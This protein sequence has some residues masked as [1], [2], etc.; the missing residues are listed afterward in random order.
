[1]RSSATQTDHKTLKGYKLVAKLD[2][3]G[4]PVNAF[5]FNAAGTLLA[6]G[7]ENIT[8]IYREQIPRICPGDDERVHIWNLH[9]LLSIQ[10]L[11]DQAHRWGQ[12]TCIKFI[13][14]N[15][16][17]TEW[18]CF[19]TGRG[20]FLIHR[21]NRKSVSSIELYICQFPEITFST[22]RLS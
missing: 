13:S 21:R 15:T 18:L 7:G 4:G 12:I 17:G 22:G 19:G 11:L 3:H 10:I 9:T 8:S 14:A 2:G 16:L 6:S 20:Q 1:M 5:A